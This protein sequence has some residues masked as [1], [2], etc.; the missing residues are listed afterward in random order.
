MHLIKGYRQIHGPFHKPIL[1]IGNFDGLHLGHQ[2]IIREVIA[3]AKK[4]GGQSVVYTFN[5]HPQAVL[6]PAR[7]VELLTTYEEKLELLGKLGVDFVIEEP[8]SREFS[9]T[10]PEQFFSQVLVKSI[11]PQAI[12]VGYDFG[13]GRDRAGSLE[14][15]RRLC[16][17][18]NIELHVTSPFKKGDEVCSSSRIR[19]HLKNGDIRAANALLGRCFRYSGPV[20]RGNARGRTIGF[21][22][23]N[24]LVGS[25]IQVKTGV[26]ATT[27]VLGGHGKPERR[28]PSVTNIGVQPTFKRDA[29]DPTELV[30]VE[31][32]IFNF[33]EDLYGSN[34][35][36]ELVERLRDE[37][38]FPSID[39]L[40]A[41]IRSD[42]EQAKK[43]L[44]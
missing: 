31:T 2:E 7:G 40:I 29:N 42:S 33:D 39:A 23:A 25:K 27:A 43:I 34:I 1:T 21:R 37:K 11:C 13:F 15:L 17:E 14:V 44:S 36:V 16:K 35:A 6:A 12:Y 22:T 4:S 26:Y 8:F 28:L 19:E 32:H 18:E 10:P 20:I 5:P 38:K 30:V 41:Q 9:E 24:I 3:R